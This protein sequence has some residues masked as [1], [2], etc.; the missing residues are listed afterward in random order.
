LGGHRLQGQLSNVPVSA[1]IRNVADPARQRGRVEALTG[2]IAE[3]RDTR[4][5]ILTCLHTMEVGG[6][7]IN[8]IEIAGTM[9]QLGH[10]AL[11][12]GP[13][14]DLRPMV[15]KLGLEFIEGPAKGPHLS[16]RSMAILR[17]TIR[18]RKIDIMHAYEWAPAMDAAYGVYL[19]AGVPIV[20][21]VLSP[22]VPD[23]VPRRF[24]L[25]VGVKEL[26][27]AE[28][29]RRPEVHLIEPPV[30]TDLNAPVVD[31]RAQRARFGVADDEVAVVAV[32]RLVAD[33]KREGLLAAIEAMGRVGAQHRMRLFIV[34]DG[35]VR[36]ELDA[37]A[38]AVNARSAPG[39]PPLVTMVGQMFDPRDAYA[40]ADIV[41][42]MGS[43][44]LRGMSFA[45]PLVVQ[46]EQAYWEL[47]TPETLPKFLD[48]GWYALGD[49]VDGPGKLAAILGPLSA[50]RAWRE[51]LG[52]LGREVVVD[53]FSLAA[54]GREQ[55]RIYEGV[56]NR[57]RPFRGRVAALAHPT[58]RYAVFRAALA[59]QAVKRQVLGV[60]QRGNATG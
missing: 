26:L 57:P 12:Y 20:V 48:G 1:S 41:L 38:A 24:P 28:R 27:E 9:A 60:G 21:T 36:G 10:E 43:S 51:E 2:S 5:R 54:A 49:G 47:L 25:V 4:V 33:L 14:G 35:P 50:D 34:G 45:K 7:Q 59:R 39:E 32:A 44:A 42:G 58:A 16:Q 15:D 3:E 8:A 30:D 40:M 29:G 46:G 31:N 37:A 23:F 13:D 17:R 18:Q 52:R 56:L 6:S 55:A 19:T 22:R 53:R 11:I